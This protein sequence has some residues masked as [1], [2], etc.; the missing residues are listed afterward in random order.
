[1]NRFRSGVDLEIGAS[2]WE[3]LLFDLAVIIVWCWKRIIYWCEGRHMICRNISG[4]VFCCNF[5]VV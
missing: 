5:F 2:V 4:P 3:N 1:M